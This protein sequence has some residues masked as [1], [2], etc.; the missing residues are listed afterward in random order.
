[1]TLSRAPLPAEAPVAFHRPCARPYPP[2]RQGK[3]HPRAR[4][5]PCLRDRLLAWERHIVMPCKKSYFIEVSETAGFSVPG[6]GVHVS[7]ARQRGKNSP[8]AGETALLARDIEPPLV[9]RSRRKGDEIL[10]EHGATPLKE[11]FA[12]WKVSEGHRQMV[13]ILADRKGIVAILGKAFGYA[14]RA[15]AG[16]LIPGDGNEDRIVVRMSREHGRGT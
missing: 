1:M 3:H 2:C 4:C 11:L 10:L 13:P 7:F 8:A 14:T 12:G 6:A 16:A 5:S 15:R 9:F